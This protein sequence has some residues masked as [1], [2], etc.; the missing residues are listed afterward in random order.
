[1]FRTRNVKLDL[2]TTST[3]LNIIIM[4]LFAQPVPAHRLPFIVATLGIGKSVGSW[5]GPDRH[6][7]ISLFR[8]NFAR[9]RS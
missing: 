8:Q 6:P 5:N 7:A 4:G 1:M 9:M 2:S 3:L